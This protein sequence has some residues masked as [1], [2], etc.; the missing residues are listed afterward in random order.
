MGGEQEEAKGFS[1]GDLEG[2]TLYL[3][4]IAFPFFRRHVCFLFFVFCLVRSLFA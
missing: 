1:G 3:L 4:C 2:E